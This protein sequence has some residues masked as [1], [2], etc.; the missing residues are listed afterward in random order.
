MTTFYTAPTIPT[1][2][3]PNFPSQDPDDSND[4]DE[5]ED[6]DIEYDEEEYEY[7]DT[8]ISSDDSTDSELNYIHG[9]E[10]SEE[11]E[12]TDGDD[13]IS[14]YAGDDDLY[15][16]DGNDVLIGTDLISLGAGEIDYLIGGEG[17]DLFLLGT[18]D[19]AFYVEEGADD[20]A[21][22]FDYSADEGDWIFA[23]GTA[24]DYELVPIDDSDSVEILYQGEMVGLV[25]DYPDLDLSNDFIF[26]DEIADA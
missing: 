21:R 7:E 3:P 9:D 22:I 11:L 25:D 26:W 17:E 12:G 24:E 2:I 14:G 20:F 18:S 15:G 19:E 1:W 16:E 5:Y 4:S 8:D 13:G 10:T 23:Y 6:T